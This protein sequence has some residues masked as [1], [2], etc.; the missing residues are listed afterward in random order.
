MTQ[1]CSLNHLTDQRDSSLDNLNEMII[2]ENVLSITE[3]GNLSTSEVCSHFFEKIDIKI[4]HIKKV[5]VM[6]L[7]FK[8]L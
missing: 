2:N 7:I 4:I 5:T 3:R 6:L 8:Q 1:K